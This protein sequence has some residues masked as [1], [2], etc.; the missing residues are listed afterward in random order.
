[1]KNTGDASAAL[2][3]SKNVV[4]VEIEL[5][6]LAHTPI[7]PLNCVA[8]LEKDNCELWYAC[9]MPTVDQQ[10]VAE[11]VGLKPAQVKINTLYAGGR[12]GRRACANDYVV[13]AANIAKQVPG[14]A[15]KMVWTREDE[16]LNARY[17]PMAVHHIRGAVA[18]GKLIAWQH[19]AVA[20]PILRGTPFEGFI[21]GPVDG[22]VAEGISDMHYAIPNLQVQ[23]TELPVKVSALWWRSVGNSGNAFV[24]ETVI[25]QLAKVA[26]KDPVVFRRELLAREPRAL[27][28]LNLAVEKSDWSKPLPKGIGRGVAV[29]KSFGTWVAQVA[30]VR[31]K[32]DGSF[33]VE[34][35]TCAV[36]CGVAVNPDVIRA[37][38]E[39]GIG[40]GLSAALGEAIT[41]NKGVVEQTNYH[42]Y[43]LMRI[44][45]MPKVDVHIVPSAEV[46]SGVGEPGLPPIAG[47]VAN[48][49]FAATGKPVKRLPIGE[50]V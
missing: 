34:R 23:A 33:K 47:A 15:V 30:E 9:Q 37:Q 14:R 31:V 48:A 2:A 26:K 44:D 24:V 46:P 38:M 1:M 32:E 27:G 49:L 39:G 11:V 16:I 4:E 21:Q 7:E 45:S 13:D 42:T 5:P 17:R 25:D 3:S 40:M 18:D 19:H 36:D 50:K 8:K 12:F 20:Q 28:A 29:H 43:T 10:Q 41:L 35:V 6:Y 22:T